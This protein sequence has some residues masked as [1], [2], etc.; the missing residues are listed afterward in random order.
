MCNVRARWRTNP[1]PSACLP[2]ASI[3]IGKWWCEMEPCLEG[4][5]CKTLPDNSGWMCSSGNKIK[6]TRVRPHAHTRMQLSVFFFAGADLHTRVSYMHVALLWLHANI[7]RKQ[8]PE[9]QTCC[10]CKSIQTRC[11]Y[12]NFIESNPLCQTCGWKRTSNTAELRPARVSL[13]RTA[14]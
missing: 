5:E 4:E 8:A 13:L 6:T 14:A 11:V 12:L 3:V 7:F 2:S 9:Q 10:G 1:A